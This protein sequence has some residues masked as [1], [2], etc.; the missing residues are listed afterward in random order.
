[1]TEHSQSER[2]LSEPRAQLDPAL[3][4]HP[5]MVHAFR[6]ALRDRPTA[7]AL[8]CGERRLSYAQLGR[9]VAALSARLS[10]LDV[11][12]ARVALA[13][14]N[15]CEAVVAVLAA[16]SARAQIAPI[17]PFFTPPELEVVLREARPRLV[18]SG[19]EARDKL[20]PLAESAGAQ[21]CCFGGAGP[22]ALDLDT[23]LAASGELPRDAPEA[24]APALLIFTGGTTGEP[25]AVEHSHRSLMVS[26]LQH[27]SAWP[28]PSGADRFLS[29]APLFHIWGLAYATLVPIYAQGT[30]VIV[31]RYQPEE[32]LRVLER[33][34]ISVFG[35]GPAPIYMGLLQSPSFAGT[36][37]SS[38]RYCLSGGAPCPEE[39]HRAWLQGTGCPLLEGWGMSEAAPLC[40][41]RPN[42]VRKL[43]SVGRPVP[44]TD[45]EVVDLETG[46]NVLPPG[47]AG[48]VRVR[49]PQ[50]MRR[51]QGR[52]E[53]TREVLRDGWLYT[54]DIGYLDAD[55]Y[56]FL[57]DR[58]KDMILV[59]GYNVYPRQVD[60][61]LFKHP[62]IVEAATVG[63]ADARLGE[64]LVAF[65]VL[66]AGA[67]LSEADFF[68]YCRA[69]L[70]KYRRPVTV[71]FVEALP[72]TNA[73]KLD[74][75]ALRARA[76]A[77]P[78]SS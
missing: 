68:E 58:K 41:N 55:G 69:N 53:A 21:L 54:G 70:V 51:Y 23:L 33:E 27:C 37:F 73:G 76:A 2:S 72:R 8:V 19:P 38:L 11:A 31:P 13:L 40:L 14:S 12:G 39:L 10:E 18:I 3:V 62:A 74:K 44:E 22:A 59:G 61:V 29:V 65:V 25:K 15:C 17:N 42:A 4:R 75:G 9:A 47:Q 1:V 34:R 45:V 64:V 48:E 7:L 26:V 52:P 28:V 30:L 46:A 16:W 5:S 32:V 6:A 77:L 24:E 78:I 20:Q 56:L 35:G 63:R 66:R 43:L 50:L 57:V 60:E 71:S 49:G 67:T 36:D